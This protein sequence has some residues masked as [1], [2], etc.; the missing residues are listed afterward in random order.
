MTAH[1]GLAGGVSAPRNG[2]HVVHCHDARQQ[3]IVSCRWAICRLT[4]LDSRSRELTIAWKSPALPLAW[5]RKGPSNAG[6]WSGSVKSAEYVVLAWAMPVMPKVNEP[7][8]RACA[9]RRRSGRGPAARG[10]LPAMHGSSMP[11]KISR[12]TAS[13]GVL[14]LAPA[15]TTSACEVHPEGPLGRQP[16]AAC[17]RLRAVKPTMPAPASSNSHVSG[18]G[19]GADSVGD[20]ET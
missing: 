16:S 10:C 3:R 4:V 1:I 6:R 13:F 12:A 18:S 5:Q 8:Q 15:G 2:G 7:G 14:L 9:C 20:T 19:T 11:P 17:C